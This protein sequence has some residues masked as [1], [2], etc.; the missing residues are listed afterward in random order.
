MDDSTEVNVAILT[1]LSEQVYKSN[2]AKELEVINERI[3]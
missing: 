3:E 1:P 2:E